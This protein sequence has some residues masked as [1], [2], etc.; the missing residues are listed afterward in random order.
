MSS[1][2]REIDSYEK[3]FTYLD[4]SDR[5]TSRESEF[6]DKLD[7]IDD[8]DKYKV[9][10]RLLQREGNL[11]LQDR[12]NGYTPL[13]YALWLITEDSD[14]GIGLYP[15]IDDW[16]KLL[17]LK[18]SDVEYTNDGVSVLNYF[19]RIK[20]FYTNEDEEEFEFFIGDLTPA[21]VR[22]KINKIEDY[23]TGKSVKKIQS[24]FRGNKSRLESKAEGRITKKQL[25]SDWLS[26]KRQMQASGFKRD[27]I[28]RFYNDHYRASLKKKRRSSKKKKKRRSSKKKKKSKN[29]KR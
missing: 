4:G 21:Q 29:R 8:I 6:Q 17:V 19:Q 22:T 3:I 16:V 13:Y 9:N 24:R 25:E 1:H 10:V 20:D 26:L 27:Q 11:Y 5:E 7:Q 2:Q 15:E 18:G 12:R 14:A 23:L 28:E